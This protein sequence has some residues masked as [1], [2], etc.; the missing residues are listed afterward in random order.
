MRETTAHRNAFSAYWELGAD[1]SIERLR[2][3]LAEERR[4]PSLRSLYKWSSEFRWQ[5]RINKLEA[6]AR[7]EEDEL[8]IAAIREMY[9]RHA[10]EALLLQQRGT[11]WLA[12]MDGT[13]L[14]PDTAIRA[15]VEGVRME[16]LAKGEPTDRKEIQGEL[17]I[18]TRIE[19]LA[20]EELDRLLALVERGVEGE[21]GPQSE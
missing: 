11:E 4:A 3:Y 21:G 7:R 5:D 2:A 13:R 9:E 15:V 16:R 17:S 18:R 12:N 8:R 20:D 10:R 6:E 1:R 14:K 19:A